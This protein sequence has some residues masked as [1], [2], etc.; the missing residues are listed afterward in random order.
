[1]IIGLH[2]YDII[3]GLGLTFCI[4]FVLGMLFEY[5]GGDDD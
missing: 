5:K 4:S 1:M 3:G 2:L